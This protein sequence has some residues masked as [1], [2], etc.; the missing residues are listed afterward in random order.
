MHM[1]VVA[2]PCEAIAHHKAR[3]SNRGGV[4][5]QVPD[6]QRVIV[7][8]LTKSCAFS[9]MNI[10]FILNHAN[11]SMACTAILLNNCA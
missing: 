7:I 9:R 6:D 4:P 1:K 10:D 11:L 3:C 2:M 5:N 8:T